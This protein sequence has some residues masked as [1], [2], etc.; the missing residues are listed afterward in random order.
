M[1][2]FDFILKNQDGSEEDLFDLEAG[3]YVDIPVEKVHTLLNL[4]DKPVFFI[5]FSDKEFNKKD[6]YEV[7]PK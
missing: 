6:T 5:T 1:A 3:D 7:E 4:T 2:Y